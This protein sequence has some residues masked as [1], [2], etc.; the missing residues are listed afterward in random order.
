[1]PNDGKEGYEGKRAIF[2]RGVYYQE[3]RNGK[4]WKL[5]FCGADSYTG[6]E[7]ICNQMRAAVGGIKTLPAGVRLIPAFRARWARL[8]VFIPLR[9]TVIILN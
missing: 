4:L 7:Q 9:K 5:I 2:V 8:D 1:M 3:Q 6:L